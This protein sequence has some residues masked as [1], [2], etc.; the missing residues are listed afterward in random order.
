MTWR[1]GRGLKGKKEVNCKE[2]LALS[3]LWPQG[4]EMASLEEEAGGGQM[5]ILGSQQ[6]GQQHAPPVGSLLGEGGLVES[7]R[8]WPGRHGISEWTQPVHGSN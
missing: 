8:A 1:E 2:L 7:Q 3:S 4:R 5:V 6:T